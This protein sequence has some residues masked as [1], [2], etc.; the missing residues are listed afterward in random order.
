MVFLQQ[1]VGFRAVG[2]RGDRSGHDVVDGATVE[3][4]KNEN[5]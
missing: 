2:A 3:T 1:R 5:G 4:L